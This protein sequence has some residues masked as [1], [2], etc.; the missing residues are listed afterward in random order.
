MRDFICP[1]LLT[2][3]RHL[4]HGDDWRYELKYDGYRGQLH[5]NG[6]GARIFTRTGLDWTARFAKLATALEGWA[7]SGLCLDGEIVAF[8]EENRPNYTTL[9]S[10]LDGNGDLHFMAFDVLAVHG[11]STLHLSLNDRR[12]ILE[13]VCH[14]APP[15]LRLVP[16]SNDGTALLDFARAN[17]WEGVVAKRVDSTYGAGQRL[18]TWRKIKCL[19][20]QEFIVLGWRPDMRTGELRSLVIGTLDAGRLT[21]RGSVGTGFTKAQRLEL[22]DE[23]RALGLGEALQDGGR[24]PPFLPVSPHLV[25]EI[26]FQEFSNHGIVRQPTFLG[27][28]SDKPIAEIC[29]EVP[30]H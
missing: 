27:L 17:A 13:E 20:R 11:Q 18:P 9:C 22:A 24:T 19:V 7:F 4:P 2:P 15:V 8:D 6:H 16:Q 1:Q 30:R 29:C 28:R 5:L 10:R 26:Q 23:L 14:D 25:A 12:T 3:S 21:C